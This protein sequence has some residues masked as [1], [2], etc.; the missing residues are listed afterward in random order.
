MFTRSI[1]PLSLALNSEGA[2][3]EWVQLLPAGPQIVG[4]DGRQWRLDDPQALVRGFD[5]VKPLQID[6]EHS[7]QI[8]APKGEPAP[9]VGWIEALELRGGELWGRVSWTPS[10]AD[11][12]ATRAYRFLSPVFAH[13]ADLRITRFVSAGLTNSPN[14]EMTALNAEEQETSNMTMAAICKA[15]GLA[16]TAT[17]ADALTAI[18]QLQ[19]RERVALNAAQTPDPSKFVPVADHQLALN[20]LAQHDA[21]AAARAEAAVTAAVD[22]AVAG[23][24]IAPSSREYHL[25]ACR[26]EGGL[27]RF[28]AAMVSAPVIAPSGVVNGDPASKGRVATAEELAACRALGLSVDEFLSAK[29]E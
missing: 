18:N 28:S 29:Q 1:S 9:A 6:F 8:K 3:P 22:A 17:D 5:P 20:R 16:E 24:K 23:G 19:E 10:G 26:A 11:A 2:A 12:V 21:A 14:L 7:S 25:A 13:T 15:L 4:R 27:E